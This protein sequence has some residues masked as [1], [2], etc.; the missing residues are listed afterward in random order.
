MGG[1]EVEEG[2]GES[3]QGRHGLGVRS[4]VRVGGGEEGE[5][6]GSGCMWEGV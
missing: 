1:I 4:I 2:W 5:R 6:G 3:G